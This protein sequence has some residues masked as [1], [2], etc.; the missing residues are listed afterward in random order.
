MSKKPQWTEKGSMKLLENVVNFPHPSQ[1]AEVMK[2]TL[3]PL[4]QERKTFFPQQMTVFMIL[5][6]FYWRPLLIYH[7]WPLYL[8]HYEQRLE[9]MLKVAISLGNSVN[10]PWQKRSFTGKR[11]ETHFLGFTPLDIAVVSTKWLYLSSGGRCG[12]FKACNSASIGPT[13]ALP[14]GPSLAF[15][16]SKHCHAVAVCNTI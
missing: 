12:W 16:K 10:E 1:I 3:V 9:G 7:S 8:C 11:M 2:S 15:S 5:E 13:E 14:N 4:V 6:E